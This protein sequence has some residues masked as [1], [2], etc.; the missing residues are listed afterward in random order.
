MKPAV[1]VVGVVLLVGSL[2]CASTPVRFQ[3]MTPGSDDASTS[4]QVSAEACGFH[5][6]GLIP[7]KINSRQR[8]AQQSL[9]RAAPGA[10]L[11]DVRVRER[12]MYALVGNM[13]CT[14]ITAKA[15]TRSGAQ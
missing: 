3:A 2:G 12:W 6:F 1:G 10:Y 4:R 7:I 5:L 8:R 11:T 14:E 13:F 15:Y 9:E